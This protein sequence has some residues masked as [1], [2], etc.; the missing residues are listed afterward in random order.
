[1][2]GVTHWTYSNNVDTLTDRYCTSMSGSKKEK[3]RNRREV[4]NGMCGYIN[5][6]FI[7]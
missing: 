5:E 1:M 7:E 4:C 3:E 6:Q 2:L